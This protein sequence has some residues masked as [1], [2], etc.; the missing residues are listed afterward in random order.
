MKKTLLICLCFFSVFTCLAYAFPINT[1]LEEDTDSAYFA[2]DC[3]VWK[4]QNLGAIDVGKLDKS[5]DLIL[6]HSDLVIF[7]QVISQF[8]LVL[9]TLKHSC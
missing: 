2:N 8:L 1:R 9:Q 6:A 3:L 5:D 4:Q 7:Q